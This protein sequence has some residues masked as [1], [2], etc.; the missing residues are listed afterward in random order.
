M[1]KRWALEEGF[2][3]QEA[4]TIAAADWNVDAVHNVRVWANKG[5]HFAWLGAKRRAR[6]LLSE[7]LCRGDLVALGEALHCSQDAIGH[8]FWGHVVHWDGIDRWER[9]G[10]GVRQRLESVSRRLL[11]EYHSAASLG[12]ASQPGGTIGE[13]A[14]DNVTI[15]P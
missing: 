2:S 5:Y 14:K 13:E 11:A 1:T 6:R 3:E 8:G 7:A 4:E 9:R 12:V 15:E 10:D